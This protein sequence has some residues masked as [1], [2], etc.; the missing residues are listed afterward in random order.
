MKDERE[1][2]AP[3]QTPEGDGPEARHG[4]EHDPHH[5]QGEDEASAFLGGDAVDPYS[6]VNLHELPP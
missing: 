2:G 1:E 6:G 5:S 4:D 3:R